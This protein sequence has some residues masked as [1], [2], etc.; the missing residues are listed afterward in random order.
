MVRKKLSK[1]ISHFA[2]IHSDNRSQ[3]F[4]PSSQGIMKNDDFMHGGS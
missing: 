1:A 4:S 3:I 2:K